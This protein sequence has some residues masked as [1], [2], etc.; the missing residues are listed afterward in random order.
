MSKTFKGTINVDIRDSEPDW[1]PFEPP[2]APDG[3]PNVV[4]IV[5]D[6]VGFS[7]MSCYGGP[8]ET[9][10]IDR[11]AAD[12]R[13]LHPVAHDR[14]L[15]A[16]PLVP[17]DRAQPHP[18]QHGLHHRGGDRVPER[19]RHDPAGERHALRDPRRARLEH[20]HGRQVAP[21]PRRRDERRLDA[22]ELA[23]PAAGSSAGTGSSAPRRTSGIPDLVYDN[24]PVDQPKSPEE[25]YHFTEDITD[26]AIEFIKDAK[27][28]APEKPFF[29]YYAPGAA[30]R[31]TT[32]PKEWADRYK[33]QFD[34]GYEAMREQTLARQKELGIVPADT[35]LPPINPIGTPE[36]RTGPDGKPFPA[37]DETRPW[38]SLSDEEKRLFA[39]WPRCTRGS[40]RTP[41]TRSAGCSTTSRRPGSARTRWS[42]W[43]RTTGRAAR[44]ARTARSTR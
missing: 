29:L 16:D 31:R 43:C 18:Q 36:T 30:T 3:A 11:I 39:G 17:A 35:E 41:T 42:S 7:A 32:R 19:E 22:A 13:P 2:K 21:V 9:P 33:G 24:H 5:L 27:A 37:L 14:A 26:K 8:I 28:I 6:D 20:L 23:D 12:G 15:L 25:G 38:D 1:A 4:Y 34:M 10:N 44:A 40:C